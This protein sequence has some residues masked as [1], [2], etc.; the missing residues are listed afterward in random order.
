MQQASIF[1]VICIGSDVSNFFFVQ[2]KKQQRKND[3]VRKKK[4][5]LPLKKQPNAKRRNRPQL[6]AESVSRNVPLPQ[7]KP[8]FKESERK[9]H[10]LA[11]KKRLQREQPR[12]RAYPY[13]A[14]PALLHSLLA[15]SVARTAEKAYLGDA[16]LMWHLVPP[17]LGRRVLVRPHKNGS[18]GLLQVGVGERKRRLEGLLRLLELRPHVLQRGKSQRRMMMAFRLSRQYTDPDKRV[19]SLALLFR[20]FLS[21]VQDPSLIYLMSIL[22]R[23]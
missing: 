22:Y 11:R 3:F 2:Q 15:V 23:L 6:Y 16:V 20:V 7:R 5:N 9:K 14:N 17:H 19:V 21:F 10:W 12:K 13:C 1:R 4:L 18:R 8:V